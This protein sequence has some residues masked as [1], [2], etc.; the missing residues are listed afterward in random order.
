M[1]RTEIKSSVSYCPPWRKQLKI[2]TL[3]FQR[4]LFSKM[5]STR[6]KCSRK[7]QEKGH[8]LTLAPQIVGDYG[9]WQLKVVLLLWIPMFFCG[10]QFVTTDLMNMEPKVL[11]CKASATCTSYDTIF[12]PNSR[13][14]CFTF[15]SH[16]C[17]KNSNFQWVK[18]GGTHR[19]ELGL[20]Q[21][22]FPGDHRSLSPGQPC[23]H[24]DGGFEG[25]R[26]FAF[27]FY[28]RAS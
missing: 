13:S 12:L 9:R 1:R 28:L 10:T 11:F 26:K 7:I 6:Y 25:L 18:A 27:K 24:Q 4:N 16:D 5:C 14:V 21:K 8:Q 17:S 15:L 23:R 22:D 3:E 2:L 20:L 19:G